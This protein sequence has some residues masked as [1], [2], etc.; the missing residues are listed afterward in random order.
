MKLQVISSPSPLEGP[1]VH[2]AH[3]RFENVRTHFRWRNDPTLSFFTGAHPFQ[4]ESYRSFADRFDVRLRH[5]NP[6]V[7]EF[8]IHDGEDALIGYAFIE[9]SETTPHEGHIGLF[10]GDAERRHQG[11]A[12]DALD[13]LL[14]YAF[15]TLHLHRLI[16]DTLSLNIA[17]QTLLKNAHFQQETRR[18]DYVYHDGAFCDQVTYGLLASEYFGTHAKAA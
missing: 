7:H 13:L 15:R 10:I 8:E 18:R 17:W 9:R 2:L 5:P 4:Q 14:S 3:L 11:Y 6:A 16:A 12:H 1:R